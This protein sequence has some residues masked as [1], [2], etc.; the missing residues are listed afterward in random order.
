MIF[1]GDVATPFSKSPSIPSQPWG[2]PILIANLEGDIAD[3]SPASFHDPVVFNSPA[4][5]DYLQDLGVR[6]VSLANN[7]I[8]DIHTSP[9]S[10]IQ[11]LSEKGITAFGAGDNIGQ[12][13]QPAIL[14]TK[15]GQVVLLG[16]GWDVIECRAATSTRPGVNPLRAQEVLLQVKRVRSRFPDASL[17]LFMHWNYEL[18]LY[19]QPMHRQLAF[20]AIDAGADAVIGTHSH[21]V[22]GIEVYRGAPIAHGLGNWMFPQ[23]EFFGGEL[24]YPDCASVQLAFE[25]NPKDGNM[26][27]HWFRYESQPHR[28]THIET[29][30]VGESERVRRLTPFAGMNHDDYIA[31]FRRNRVKRKLLPVYSS[32]DEPIRNRLRDVWVGARGRLLRASMHL[33]L[34]S[35]GRSS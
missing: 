29:Q 8:L 24:T 17:V 11:K 35:R 20:R 15:E 12:A 14:G 34:K 22:Q 16:F 19:P 4:V 30:P 3:H 23:G 18:E 27:C 2:D 9:L 1:I 10:T 21:R 25:W 7:H 32:C 33:G 28:I 26:L 13:R 31:F 5:T 6:A